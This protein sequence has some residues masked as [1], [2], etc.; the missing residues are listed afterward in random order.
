MLEVV[1]KTFTD[2][3]TKLALANT[4][5]PIFRAFYREEKNS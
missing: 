4:R 2:Y 1:R 5:S 3:T